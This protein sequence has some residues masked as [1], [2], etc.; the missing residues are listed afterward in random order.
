MEASL[1]DNGIRYNP[2]FLARARE[3]QKE[4]RLKAER[5][6]RARQ[7]EEERAIMMRPK[8]APTEAEIIRVRTWEE[9]RAEAARR[10]NEAN[11]ALLALR[12][13]SSRITYNTIERRFCLAIGVTRDELRSESR[14]RRIV[15]CRQAIAYWCRRCTD[16]TLPEIGHRMGG[17]DHSTILHGARNYPAK[18]EREGR[19]PRELEAYR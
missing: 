15:L 7:R 14:K 17:F 6:E 18:R 9:Q 4:E 10:F 19:F 8:P 13:R 2:K 5:A 12:G 3:R 11:K 1:H 16:M